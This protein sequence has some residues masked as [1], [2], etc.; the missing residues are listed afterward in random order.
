MNV[1]LKDMKLL[2]EINREELQLRRY[3]TDFSDVIIW[4]SGVQNSNAIDN[5]TEGLD[6]WEAQMRSMPFWNIVEHE[7]RN[8]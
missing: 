6:A 1:K 4:D 5:S 7:R 3:V 2:F 8:V